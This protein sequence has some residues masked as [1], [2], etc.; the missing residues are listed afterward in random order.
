MVGWA[1]RRLTEAVGFVLLLGSVHAFSNGPLVKE[2]APTAVAASPRARRGLQLRRAAAEID[3]RQR[4]L[5]QRRWLNL[6]PK[7]A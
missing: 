7:S 6:G 3:A 2:R 5:G 4:W 1:P